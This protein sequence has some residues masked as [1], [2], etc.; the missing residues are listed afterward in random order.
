M[1]H[2]LLW[3]LFVAFVL[4][5]LFLDL[6]VL[7]RKAHEVSLKHALIQTACF[8]ALGALFAGAIYAIYLNDVGDRGTMFAHRFSNEAMKAAADA[9]AAGIELP[10]A[11]QRAPI[12]DFH[13]YA[14]DASLQYLSGWLTEYALSVDNIF[15]IALIF[16]YF[17]IPNKYQHRVLFWGIMGALILRGLMIGVGAAAVERFQ[18]ILYI[19][20]AFLI[21]TAIKMVLAK[22]DD[23]ANPE[24]SLIYKIVT[25]VVRVTPTLDGEKFFTRV[26]EREGSTTLVRAATPLF[27]VLV[28]V[29]FT[30]VIFAVDSIPAIFGITRDPFIVFTSNVFAI[31]GLRSLYFALAGAMGLFTYLKPAL[32]FVLAFIGV[33]MILHMWHIDLPTWAKL[34][35]IAGA[36]TLGITASLVHASKQRKLAANTPPPPGTT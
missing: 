7:N 20:G 31:L 9:K 12:T 16:T 8:V 11:D 30:D 5:M 13:P 3:I 27:L 4:A 19:F 36:L 34:A 21:F 24:Q 32:A 33:T 15:V 6:F 14:R 17:R 26:P 10:P 23:E 18:W 29:E 22:E 1:S 25:R 2:A 35:T 28:L